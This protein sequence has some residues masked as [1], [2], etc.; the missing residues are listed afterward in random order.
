MHSEEILGHP[1][2]VGR[3]LGEQE[4]HNRGVQIDAEFL[5][6]SRSRA[7]G[8]ISCSVWFLL[9]LLILGWAFANVG[10]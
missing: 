6:G 10:E 3:I 5:H 9:V 7:N 1:P 8:L 2:E 4:V